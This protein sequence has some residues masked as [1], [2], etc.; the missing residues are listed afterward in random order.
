MALF[1]RY[2]L[3]GIIWSLLIMMVS[4]LPEEATSVSNYGAGTDKFVHIVMYAVLCLLL[5]VGFMK[6]SHNTILKF[7]AI[8]LALITSNLY[9]LLMELSQLLSPNRTFE[10]EDVLANSGG[11]VIGIAIFWILYKL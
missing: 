4:L 3:F 6:Q 2:N 1:F 11:T 7:N 10:W 8:K 5:V 9:G